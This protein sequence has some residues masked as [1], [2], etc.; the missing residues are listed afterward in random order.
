MKTKKSITIL[1][2]LCVFLL[3]NP[4]S[5]YWINKDLKNIGSHNAYDLTVVLSGSKTVAGHYDGYPIGSSN[6]KGGQ[7]SSFSSGPSGDNTQL[8]W[9]NFWD[10][11]N[12]AINVGQTIHVGWD[13]TTQSNVLDMYWT[14]SSGG[15]I[16]GSKIRNITNGWTYE[17]SSLIFTPSWNNIFTPDGGT[18]A[19]INIGNARW[20]ASSTFI[21]LDQLN[22][23]NAALI[24][25]L[26]SL[27]GGDFQVDYGATVGIDIPVQI[28]ENYYVILVYNV[29]SSDSAAETLDFV[30]IPEP[31][32][33]LLLS[34]GG[35]LLR[36][37]K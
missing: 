10:G 19:V 17:T 7:F 8:R 26:Q 3:S 36:R 31:A 29:S 32:T 2:L 21:P 14:N 9:Q 28:P 5:A 24:A 4:V 11:T 25:S 33:V 30:E 16:S 23:D 13:T 1:T 20:M 34:L 35:L 6:G 22:T 18:G 37:R 27:P 12:S 15:R